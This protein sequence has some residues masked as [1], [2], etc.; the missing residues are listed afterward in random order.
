MLLHAYALCC[1]FA[2]HRLS[3]ICIAALL[4]L[5]S[6]GGCAKKTIQNFKGNDRTMVEEA[7]VL[8]V[9]INSYHS[10]TADWPENLADVREKLPPGAVWPVNPYNG[11]EITDTGSATFDPAGSVGNV[12]YEKF[13]REDQIMNYRL[14]VFGDKGTLMI[15]GNSAFGAE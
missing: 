10:D 13:R 8:V 15:F 2:S 1:R 7:Q 6:L 14:H 11:N 4:A 9:A 12:F 3:V 5:T